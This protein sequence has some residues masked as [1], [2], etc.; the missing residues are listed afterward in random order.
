M[1]RFPASCAALSISSVPA[2]IFMPSIRI[3]IS[4]NTISPGSQNDAE[5]RGARSLVWAVNS[6]SKLLFSSHR[7]HSLSGRRA[8]R[9]RSGTPPPPPPPPQPPRSILGTFRTGTSE[10]KPEVHHAVVPVKNMG[11]ALFKQVTPRTHGIC[12]MLM[13]RDFANHCRSIISL[14]QKH[15]F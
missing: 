12:S 9:S 4:N 6:S 14:F 2:S 7:V 15:G 3:H 11:A 1:H 13:P 8:A 10:C 5:M